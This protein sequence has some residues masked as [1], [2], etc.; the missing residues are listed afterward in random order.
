MVTCEMN[1]F[2]LISVFYFTRNHVTI[3]VF[4]PLKLFQ[5]CFS[6]TECVGN[7]SRAA[8]SF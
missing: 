6:D 3:K 4:Q 2:E 5:N 7:Y 1:Y 8:M